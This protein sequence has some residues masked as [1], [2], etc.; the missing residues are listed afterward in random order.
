MIE[1]IFVYMLIGVNSFVKLEDEECAEKKGKY[2]SDIQ[3]ER[4]KL[5]QKLK[6]QNS[7][8][9]MGLLSELNYLD[10][11]N[12]TTTA[13]MSEKN[14]ERE[15]DNLENESDDSEENTLFGDNK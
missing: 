2:K 14:S 11:N 8:E 9:D 3:K 6:Q 1:V 4:R 12:E 10:I 5:E 15:E 13:S 7:D